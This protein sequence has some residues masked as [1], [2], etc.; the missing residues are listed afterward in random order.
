MVGS[1]CKPNSSSNPKRGL[2]PPLSDPTQI[3]KKSHGHK[4]LCKSP[5]EQLPGGGIA[6]AYSQKCNRN[7]TKPKISRLLQPTISSSKTKQKVE[8]YTGSEQTQSFSQGGEIQNG[9]P[10][11]HP[12]FPPRGVGY[13]NRLQGRLLPHTHT[14]EV[15]KISQISCPGSD[16]PVQ[17]TSLWP[18]NSSYGVHCNS[19]GSETDGYKQGYKNPPVPRRLVGESQL[20]PPLPSTYPKVSP[21]LSGAGLAG[22]CRKI[23]TRTQAGLRICRLSIRPPVRTGPTYSGPVASP[24][25]EDT[26]PPVTAGLSGPAI[27]V[28]DR[29]VNSHGK[30]G[31]SRSTAYE[32]HTVAPQ[33]QLEGTRIS[34]EN[35]PITQITAPS[36]KVVAGGRQCATRSTITPLEACS[37]N[38]YRR[39]KRRLGLI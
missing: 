17:S 25:G 13:L 29:P 11:N 10:G 1:G 39:I 14:P 35:Y 15:S 26:D 30:A 34:G 5:Q 38:F 8:T 31:S 18:L 28:P 22:K 21:D 2:P 36:L 19:Q 3:N 24:S 23:R 37:A 16:L 20:P 7:R 6:S 32:A 12:D 4:L 27:H 33:K 9:N